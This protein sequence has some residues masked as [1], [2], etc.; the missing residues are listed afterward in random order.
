MWQEPLSPSASRAP[1]LVDYHV[2]STFSEDAR[3]T[4][5][6]I[7]EAALR[8]GLD[9][10]VFTEHLEFPPPPGWK[11]PAYVPGRV[12]PAGEYLSAVAALREARGTELEIGA[13]AE[14][15]L[16]GHNLE[17]LDPYLERFRPD[18]DFVIG[19]L[20]SVNGT[21]VQLPEYTDPHGPA[22]AARLYLEKLVAGVKKAAAMKACDVIGHIDLFK[23]SPTF[24]PFRPDD[25]RDCLEELFRTII[26]A[27]MGLE[28]NTS[29][30]RQPPREPYPGLET[31]RL[32]RRMGGE[33]VT[34][35]SD[36]HT[37]QTVGLGSAEALD[38]IRA[39]GFR[40]MT[41]FSGRRPRFVRI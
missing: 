16:E 34:I 1:V 3:S 40:Y 12:L 11:E 24:G 14:L 32:Y 21:L 8:R 10:V 37:A 30:Y 36:S 29:G 38:F 33:I 7:V 4:P 23:R 2:H 19:S 15:G 27:G 25:Q 39:A 22:A 31:L 35:G 20:H 13:G 17:G 9:A 41:L 26:D 18:F 6:E 5:E 28:V